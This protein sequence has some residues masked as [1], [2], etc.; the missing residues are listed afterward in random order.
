MISKG[1]FQK[2]RYFRNF[3][4][5]AKKHRCLCLY[6]CLGKFCSVYLAISVWIY[7]GLTAMKQGD[8]ALNASSLVLSSVKRFI[9]TIF[10]ER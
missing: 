3:C 6:I 9:A 2:I 4:S 1:N 7:I 5:K 8:E 10:S